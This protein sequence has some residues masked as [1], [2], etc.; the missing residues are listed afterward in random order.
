M[1]EESK[2]SVLILCTGNTARSQ[3]AEAFLRHY[4]GASL[5]VFSAG[6]DP[7]EI[8]PLTRQVMAERGFDLSG[9]Y[10]KG[11]TEFLGKKQ[12]RYLIIVCAAAEAACPK[13]F[14]G[15]LF[16]LFWPFDDPAAAM[17]PPEAQLAKFREVRDQIEARLLAWLRELP[18]FDHYWDTHPLNVH[19]PAS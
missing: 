16:R 13:Q 5:D 8:H 19:I 15:V 2:P 7:K 10:A 11:V 18:S 12:F 17:G 4:A 3:M 14:P 1:N 6:Y 9:Q